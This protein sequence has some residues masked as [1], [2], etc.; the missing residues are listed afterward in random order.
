MQFLNNI[1]AKNISDLLNEFSR[2]II[3]E[4]RFQLSDYLNTC[5][6]IEGYVTTC[7]PTHT[8]IKYYSKIYS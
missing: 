3:I 7:H 5:S 8:K 4:Q 6:N 2:R 1:V